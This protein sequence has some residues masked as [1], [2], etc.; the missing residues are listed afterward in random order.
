MF[1]SFPSIVSCGRFDFTNSQ[2]AGIQ[3]MGGS[4][5]AIAETRRIEK[6]HQIGYFLDTFRGIKME[7]I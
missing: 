1:A 5:E 4:E 3:P 6:G 7:E 2:D